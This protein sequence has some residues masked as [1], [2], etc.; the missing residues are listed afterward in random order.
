MHTLQSKVST[1]AAVCGEFWSSSDWHRDNHYNDFGIA[2]DE[3]NE[4][5]LSRLPGH[6][7]SD[8]LQLKNSC[9]NAAGLPCWTFVASEAEE[10]Q[11]CPAQRD[12]LV[13]MHHAFLKLTDINALQWTKTSSAQA[14]AL[15]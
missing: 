14:Y 1:K 13:A 11:L 5:G 12:S 15:A 7:P 3:H 10:L 6:Q 8:P 9:H 2:E 4:I